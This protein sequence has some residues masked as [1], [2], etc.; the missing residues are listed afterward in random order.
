MDAVYLCYMY[1]LCT[2]Y[3]HNIK[4]IHFDDYGEGGGESCKF[5][6]SLRSPVGL[7]EFV[8]PL[9]TILFFKIFSRTA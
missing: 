2:L 3:D 1:D 5:F 7:A 6:C 4:T 9:Q 8:T